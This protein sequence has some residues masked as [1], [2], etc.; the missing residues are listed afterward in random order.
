MT[1][2]IR[3]EPVSGGDLHV[4]FRPGKAGAPVVVLVHGITANHLSGYRRVRPKTVVDRSRPHDGG[5][6]PRAEP[7]VSARHAARTT[8]IA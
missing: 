2:A 4:G 1:F 7:C 5:A 8:P 6:Q 3:E